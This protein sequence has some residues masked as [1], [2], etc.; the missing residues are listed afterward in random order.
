M[1]VDREKAYAMFERAFELEI[2]PVGLCNVAYQ[3]AYNFRTP[4]K[5]SALRLYLKSLEHA[6]VKQNID[7]Y[8]E[9]GFLFQ[10]SFEGHPTDL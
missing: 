10:E 2:C 8:V 7:C 3:L 9:A 6:D 4:D 1:P 5:P